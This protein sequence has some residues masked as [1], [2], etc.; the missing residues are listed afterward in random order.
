MTGK[1]RDVY[2]KGVG[3]L[4]TAS[5]VLYPQRICSPMVPNN[6]R[7]LAL[8]LP[9]LVASVPLL[10]YFPPVVEKFVYDSLRARRLVLG[11]PAPT[12]WPCLVCGMGQ[13]VLPSDPSPAQRRNAP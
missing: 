2:V 7:L 6:L 10:P 9:V 12:G 11:W 4:P 13:L 1:S 8:P 3:Q 5:L